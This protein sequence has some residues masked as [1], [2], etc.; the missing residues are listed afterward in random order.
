MGTYQ[1][2]RH[3]IITRQQVVARYG[4]HER[5]F[6]PHILGWK[7]GA[8]RCL[9][10]QFA[11]TSRTGRI[12]PGS[13]DNWRCLK[14]EEI[15]VIRLQSGRWYSGQ[16]HERTQRCLDTVDVDSERPDTLK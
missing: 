8:E 4:G 11:G 13:P 7:D 10:Y 1:L 14:V 9:V 3:A 6:C 12:F 16:S 15:E 5:E 2:L